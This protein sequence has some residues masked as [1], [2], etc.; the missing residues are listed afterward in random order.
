MKF[1]DWHGCSTD[2]SALLRKQDLTID[3]IGASVTAQKGSWADSFLELQKS[4]GGGCKASTKIAM[5]GVG[6]IY[7]LSNTAY[8][9]G[10]SDI[11]LL[12]F[13]T[14]DLTVGHTPLNRLA[15]ILE[16]L[17]VRLLSRGTKLVFVHNWRKDFCGQLGE[18]V[19]SQ[20]KIVA[21]KYRIPEIHNDRL[22]DCLNETNQETHSSCFRDICH[23]TKKGALLYAKH[24]FDALM[25]TCIA[26]SSDASPLQACHDR[27]ADVRFHHV[28]DWIRSGNRQ[29]GHYEYPNTGEKFTFLDLGPKESLCFRASGL[30]LGIAFM[31]WPGAGWLGVFVDGKL[32]KRIRCLDQHG[33]YA[34]FHLLPCE[35]DLNDQDVQVRVLQ[36]SVDFTIAKQQHPDFALDRHI[37][38]VAIAGAVSVAP[39]SVSII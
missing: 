19:R 18:P 15:E 2:F 26:F 20:Y 17:T 1:I 5:G 6:L 29:I 34:R 36:E 7:A 28:T 21:Q 27:Y 10:N 3:F 13:S 11:T 30:I 16:S 32:E 33:Y 24:V 25:D 14:G 31:V 35:L 38:L 8:Q 22:I 39:N 23:T 9:G 12:E 37:R 4:Q